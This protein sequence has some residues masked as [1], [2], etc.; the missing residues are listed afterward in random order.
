[1]LGSLD[2]KI[3]DLVKRTKTVK[4]HVEMCCQDKGCI[5]SDKSDFVARTKDLCLKWSQRVC[6]ELDM[7]EDSVTEDFVTFDE[8]DVVRLCDYNFHVRVS[9][10]C[11]D[12]AQ[13]A[14]VLEML[15]QTIEREMESNESDCFDSFN[16]F[17]W[18]LTSLATAASDLDRLQD[19]LVR[20]SCKNYPTCYIQ[21]LLNYAINKSFL[22]G[23]KFLLNW[24][25]QAHRYQYDNGFSVETPIKVAVGCI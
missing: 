9:I 7:D 8:P 18:I 1:M 13:K 24:G 22:D 20:Q 4:T 19:T 15:M 11:E 12:P 2:Q 23:V 3:N 16:E 21:S 17:T 25:A 6:S 5:L 14:D 10:Y